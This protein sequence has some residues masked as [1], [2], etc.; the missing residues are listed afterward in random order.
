MTTIDS[1]RYIYDE[2][3]AEILAA[4]RE[5]LQDSVALVPTCMRQR[6]SDKL[7]E[8]WVMQTAMGTNEI[9]FYFNGQVVL[10]TAPYD[11]DVLTWITAKAQLLKMTGQI[12]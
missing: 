12:R 3:R 9:V 8:T 2:D 5:G 4:I 1:S 11:P 10:N 6:H 7:C